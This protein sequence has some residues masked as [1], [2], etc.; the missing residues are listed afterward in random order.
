MSSERGSI[1]RAAQALHEAEALLVGAGA[2]MSV[3][4]G[5]PAYRLNP[6][7]EEPAAQGSKTLPALKPALFRL[8]P[9]HAWG[10]AGAALAQFRRTEPH[11]GYTLLRRW[12]DALRAGA[13]VLSSNVDGLFQ[14]AG[15]DESAIFEGH[16]SLHHLQC[17]TPC[18]QRVWPAGD[19]LS[20]DEHGRARPPL[21]CCPDCGRPA[22]PNVLMFGDARFVTTRAEAQAERYRRWLAASEGRRLV[23]IECGAGTAIPTIRL[24]CEELARARGGTLI[25]INPREAEA[26]AGAISLPL[27]SLEALG[28]IEEALTAS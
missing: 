27:A 28:A 16:G 8:D 14:R 19:D 24:R 10:I 7:P 2:G 1:Q 9:A 18:S 22:R 26:P 6:E 20:L 13:F 23:V 17:V 12:G 4:S 11:Q 5:I 25:R 3:D 21:P 15:F